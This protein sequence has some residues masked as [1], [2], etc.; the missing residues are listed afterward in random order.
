MSKAALKASIRHQDASDESVLVFE[1]V[2]KPQFVLKDHQK[3]KEE[4]RHREMREVREV[5]EGHGAVPAMPAMQHQSC[6]HGGFSPKM[7]Y[8]CTGTPGTPQALGTGIRK[9]F[10]SGHKPPALWHPE[11]LW[12][13]RINPAKREAKLGSMWKHGVCTALVNSVQIIFLYTLNFQWGWWAVLGLRM[14]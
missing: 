14:G 4:N 13:H 9:S 10:R 12:R 2:L 11:I 6:C 5:W 8:L 7:L 3:N 1:M